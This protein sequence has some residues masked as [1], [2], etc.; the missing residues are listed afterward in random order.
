MKKNETH[1]VQGFSAVQMKRELQDQFQRKTDGMTFA[2][3]R[4]F[5]DE[6]LEPLPQ[7]KLAEEN[8]NT[9]K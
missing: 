5:L 4:R 6:T 9:A 7:E 3:L 8:Q 2:E 1:A